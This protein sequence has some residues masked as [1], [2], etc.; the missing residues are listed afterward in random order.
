M[1][2]FGLDFKFNVSVILKGSRKGTFL[3]FFKIML[4]VY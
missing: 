2:F 4:L 3:L 1:L